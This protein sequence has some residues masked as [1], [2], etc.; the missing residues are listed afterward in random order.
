S[1]AAVIVAGGAGVRV[2]GDLPKQYQLIGGRPVIWWTLKAFVDHPG[3]SH[4]Q[5]V[6]GADHGS[7]FAEAIEALEILP[8][9]IGGSTRQ[10]SCRIGVAACEK[11]GA[12]KILIHDA[13][14]P[15]VSADLIS[16]IIAE[17]DRSEGVIPGL[18]MADTMKLAPGGVVE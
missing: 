8:P 13:A 14:R 9:V 5:T 6:I 15:F 11:I 7:L 10:D 17:L 1:V 18:P 4:V 3:I 12:Q 16:H 2:G